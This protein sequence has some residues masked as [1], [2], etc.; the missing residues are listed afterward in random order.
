MSPLAATQA[1]L[2][3]GLAIGALLG[4]AVQITGYCTM[5]ALA[6][7]FS[8]G[9]RARLMM[10]VLAVAV[11]APATAAAAAIGWL[12]PTHCL[13]WASRFTWLSY[14]VGGA[15]F[16][17]GMVLASGCPQRNLVRAGGGNLKALVV[18]L[19][20]GLAA[21]MTLRGAF[22]GWRVGAL[23]AA[24]LDLQTPQDLGSLLGRAAGFE[25]ALVRLI[26]LGLALAVAATLLWRERKTLEPSHWLGG[27]A[28]GLLVPLAWVLTGHIGFLAENPD[29]LEPA[30]MGTASHRPEALSFVAPLAQG[31]DLLTLWSDR[32]TVASFGVMLALGVVLGSA[33]SALLRREFRLEGFRDAED[34]ANHLAGGLLMGFGGVT[35]AGCSIGQGV[36]GLSLLS[37][38]SVIAVAGIVGGS[39]AA[40]AWQGWRLERAPA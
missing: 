28:V 34:L 35:A 1:V 36:S 9:G 2:W 19:V 23:D 39:R 26:L 12:D 5:G 10:W 21:Q 38:G 24:A 40:L 15:V 13:A 29:T 7:Y 3:G 25:P 6:D 33:A 32:A 37:A 17:F 22:A 30:W 11:A 27:L 8:F 16:G 31:L 4:A 14:A 18:L 20:A